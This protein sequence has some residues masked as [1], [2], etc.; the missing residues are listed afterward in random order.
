MNEFK[1]E[2]AHGLLKNCK[3]NKNTKHTRDFGEYI[4][5]IPCKTALSE[6]LK[7]I[8]DVNDEKCNALI[9]RLSNKSAKMTLVEY[10]AI[11]KM[12]NESMKREFGVTGAMAIFGETKSTIGLSTIF[13]NLLSLVECTRKQC[14]TKRDSKKAECMVSE[15]SSMLVICLQ[16][17]SDLYTKY[18]CDV[19][20]FEKQCNDGMVEFAKKTSELIMKINNN[21][22]LSVSEL[23][24]ISTKLRILLSIAFPLI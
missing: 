4:K 17:A 9:K 2:L 14:N 10:A 21:K 23:E 3:S 16:L 15:C 22:K 7:I 18:T 19:K 11:K 12:I 20:G 13:L 8:G 6:I 5:V 24:N 1:F